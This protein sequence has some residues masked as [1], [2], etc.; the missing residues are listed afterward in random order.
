MSNISV[1]KLFKLYVEGTEA[2][3]V[4]ADKTILLCNATKAVA[5]AC[6]LK[7]VKIYI[8]TKVLKHLYD[9][10]PAEEFDFIIHNVHT[11]AKY[12]DHI[13]KNKE[14]KRGSFIFVKE[15]KKDKYLCSIE[16]V[17]N[18]IINE[19]MEDVNFIATSYRIR[20]EKYL[21]KYELMWSWKGGRPSS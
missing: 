11:I 15:L 17:D 16:I 7:F 3:A 21:K 8:N 13:Y 14:S 12:P 2:K 10:K 5:K 20:D 6:S 1:V 9:K 4:V 19:V 18:C